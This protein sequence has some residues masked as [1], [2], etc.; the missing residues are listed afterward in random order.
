MNGFIAN[1]FTPAVGIILLLTILFEDDQMRREKKRGF[2]VAALLFAL[3]LVVRNAEYITA[4]YETYTEWRAVWSA[5]LYLLRAAL[6]YIILGLELDLSKKLPKIMYAILSLPLLIMAAA[7]FSVFFTDA[8][9]GFTGSNHFYTGGLGAFRYIPLLLYFLAILIVLLRDLLRSKREIIVLGFECLAL[10]IAAMAFEFFAM[11]A[12][13]CETAI[14]LGLV[15]YFLY[16]RTNELINENEN[17]SVAAHMDGLTGAYNRRGYEAIVDANR[18]RWT[19]VG[20]LIMDIDKFK[21]INDTFGHDIG[22]RMLKRLS[23][24][25]QS[26]FRSSDYVIRFGGDEFVI[27]LPGITK[28]YGEVVCNK[29]EALNVQLENPIS[30]LPVTS[31]SAGIAFSEHGVSEELYTNADKTLYEVKS[32]TR[33]GCKVFEG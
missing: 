3:V 10:I 12:F 18:E 13:L 20:F 7:A 17:L 16:F 26:T 27:L 19:D 28:E 24:L 30:D 8:V 23:N 1:N 32:T 31:I 5:L 25:L 4:D 9:Y 11:P 15:F 14:I 29:I 6:L 22:D 2:I 33:R 21:E